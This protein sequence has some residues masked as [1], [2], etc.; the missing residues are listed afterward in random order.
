MKGPCSNFFD[1]CARSILQ[2]QRFLY[3]VSIDDEANNFLPDLI[4]AFSN[5]MYLDER[6]EGDNIYINESFIQKKAGK[7]IKDQMLLNKL[8]SHINDPKMKD[9]LSGKTKYAIEELNMYGVPAFVIDDEFFFGSD[10]FEQI[11]FLK[12]KPWYGPNPDM[13]K[14]S[15]L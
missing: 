6:S 13:S 4:T 12:G 9:G 1:E 15:K 5:A 7:V 11:A 8:V 3:A 2:V 14:F 10:R